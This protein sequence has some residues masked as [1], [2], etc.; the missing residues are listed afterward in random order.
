[1][2][3]MVENKLDVLALTETWLGADE[4]ALEVEVKDWGH[5]LV[6]SARQGAKGGGVAF[7]LRRN[8]KY[9]RHRTATS[10]FECLEIFVKG[11]VGLRLAVIYRTGNDHS[12][13]LAEFG[14]YL[15]SFVSKGG[16]PILLGDFNVRFQDDTDRFTQKFKALLDSEGWLQHVA[17]PTHN[18]GSTLDLVLTRSSDL[19]SLEELENYWAP[20]LPDHSLV[21]FVLGVVGSSSTQDFKMVTS[22]RMKDFDIEDLREDVLRSNLCGDLP[23]DLNEC[24]A[25]YDTSLRGFM[26]SR[27]PVVTRKVRVRNAPWFNASY[28]VCQEAKRKRRAKE[29]AYRK[30][31]RQSTSSGEIQKH[32]EICKAQ[33]KET[34]R[35]LRDAREKYFSSRLEAQQHDPRATWQT[36]NHLLGREKVEVLPG[37]IEKEAMADAFMGAF[38][39]KVE[40]IYNSLEQKRKD[41]PDGPEEVR[42]YRSSVP[43]FKF[44]KVSDETLR[45]TIKEMGNK[46]CGLDPI[47]T[48]FVKKLFGELLPVLSKTVNDSLLSGVF[49]ESLKTANIRPTIKKADLDPDVLGNYRPVSNLPFLGKLIEKCACD[50]FV[51][52]LED[53]SLLS[54]YQSAYRK[55]R[56]CETATLRIFDDL[57]TLTDA[58]TKVVLLLLDLSAA[59]DT[60]NHSILLKRLETI[61]GVRGKALDW[62]T[63]YLTGRTASVVLGNMSS[64]LVDLAIGV[65]QGSILGPILFICY[66]SEM[67]V[68][69][70]R[71]GLSIHFYADD[72]QVYAA[73]SPDEFSEMEQK[74]KACVS[75]IQNWLT[76]NFLQLNPSKTEV[77]ILSPRT[78]NGDVNEVDLFEGEDRLS[79]TDSARN[80][81]V[82]FDSRLSFDKHV[83]MVTRACNATLVN[84]W[85]IGT[86]LSRKLKTTLVTSLIHG[87]LDYCNSLLSGMTKKNVAKLQKVQNAAARFIFGQRHRQGTTELRR[88]LHFLP[89][90]ERIQFKTGVMVYKCLNGL[91]PE[92]LSELLH[93][94]RRKKTS[95][96]MD[97]DDLLLEQVHTR[98]KTSERAFR[99]SGPRFWN[100]LP[101]KIRA[102]ETLE[103]F[104]KDLKTYLFQQAF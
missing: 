22:R 34:E 95:L 13:F 46:H 3:M 14:E 30:V 17:G 41:I 76:N 94:R 11:S 26:D 55:Q 103:I 99:V 35:I 51:Q 32:L 82:Y 42:G 49:P 12:Q 77:L 72:T 47:P 5:V 88:I 7:I 67:D 79:T 21:S 89:V 65:P 19:S 68:I 96:R 60:V 61:Y 33:V 1:M 54:K 83:A 81:G 39:G 59:F 28:E 29:R 58:K 18:R 93:K 62:F 69:A 86:K 90:C 40:K 2:G 85:R 9:S 91:A 97:N 20:E 92:Y 104:K 80:L 6:S 64:V 101:R 24:V 57:L 70:G 38:Q 66:T 63:S 44:Q 31:L 45:A 78:D 36:A 102:A 37:N 74:L 100:S 71:H 56:S 87:K 4:S 8:I 16:V 73:F 48:S 75:D 52:H 15:I 23:E 53:H 84:L 43:E 25:L 10:T 27:A 50:Q 98:Y